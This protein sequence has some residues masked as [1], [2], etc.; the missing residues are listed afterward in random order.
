MELIFNAQKSDIIA[1]FLPELGDSLEDQELAAKVLKIYTKMKE[2]A[3]KSYGRLK[4]VKT[5]TGY[6]ASNT[7][8]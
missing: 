4:L 8:P 1:K 6:R 7:S 5:G 3:L 2:K